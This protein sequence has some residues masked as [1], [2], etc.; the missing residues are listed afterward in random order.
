VPAARSSALQRALDEHLFGHTQREQHL[1]RL[2]IDVRPKPSDLLTEY[3]QKEI[4]RWRQV[5]E[6]ISLSPG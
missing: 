1:Q 5:I 2:G 4:A 3:Q 6:A